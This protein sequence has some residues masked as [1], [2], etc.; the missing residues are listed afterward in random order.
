MRLAWIDGLD[1]VQRLR[2]VQRGLIQPRGPDPHANS[3]RPFYCDYL[4]AEFLA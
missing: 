1:I 3:A 2:I 4:A